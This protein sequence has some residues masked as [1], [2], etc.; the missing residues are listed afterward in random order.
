MVFDFRLR[1][2]SMACSA[3]IDGFLSPIEAPIL[4]EF[5][6]LANDAGRV[7]RVH[8]EIGVIPFP[9][10]PQA[11]EL[12]SLDVDELLCIFPTAPPDLKG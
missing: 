4:S 5:P 12:F 7:L 11:L 8:G 10:H 2:S 1:Q 9:E 3:P 6:E